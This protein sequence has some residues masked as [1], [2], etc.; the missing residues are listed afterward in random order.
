[1]SENKLI[2][3]AAGSGK[4]THLVNEALSRSDSNV[5]ILTYTQ[6]NEVAIKAN[7]R[8]HANCIPKNITVQ[9][10]F[11]F[12]LQH[13]V[14]PYQGSLDESLFDLNIRGM[15]LV[16]K[17]SAIRYTGGHGPVYWS[18][19]EHFHKHYFNKENKIYSDKI[20]KFV[21]RCNHKSSNAVV[22]RIARIYDFISIDEV[23]DLAGY[24]LE[25]IKLLFKSS[26]SILLVGDPRQVTYL[27]HI[28]RK[29]A[30]YKNGRIKAFVESNDCRGTRCTVDE[31]TLNVS[32]RNNLAICEYSSRLYPEYSNTFPCTCCRQQETDHEG[33]FLL[34]PDDIVE[35]TQKYDVMQLRWDSRKNVLADVPVMNF[36]ESKGHTFGR[37]LIYPTDDMINWIANNSHGLSDGAKA[38]FYV[39][40]TRAKH[41]VAIVMDY[42]TGIEYEGVNKWGDGNE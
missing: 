13:G 27:T 35:Y 6:S 20:S 10:W 33:V 14:K 26:A 1:M 42:D 21:V 18:E 40:L 30:K 4:T 29:F 28:E 41:S 2:I 8:H 15:L 23:Q 22:D 3:A 25:L 7:I 32:H 39:A 12:L 16:N 17:Q 5:L 37:V 36:G 38:K 19:G 34:K 31:T 11:S 24:D 9:T